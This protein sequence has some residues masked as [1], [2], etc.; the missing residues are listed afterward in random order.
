MRL[1]RGV[2]MFPNDTLRRED[3]L[4][5]LSGRV[6]GFHVGGKTALAWRGIRHNIPAREQLSLWGE[7]KT[8][9]P[10]WFQE[11]SLAP[12]G[13]KPIFHTAEELRFA[14]AAGNAGRCSRVR[15]G[16]GVAGNVERSRSSPGNRGSPQYHGG[17]KVAATGGVG[18][19]A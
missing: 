13:A 19:A 15:A 12:H 14:A 3:C 11:L 17:R 9:L 4:K 18:N 10:D 2:F 7:G 16:K 5:F 6:P 8:R 1:G